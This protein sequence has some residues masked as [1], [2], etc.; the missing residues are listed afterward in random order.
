MPSAASFSGESAEPAYPRQVPVVCIRANA[1]TSH[2]A[3]SLKLEQT[4]LPMVTPRS[5]ASSAA[6]PSPSVTSSTVNT[7][8]ATTTEPHHLPSTYG[9]ALNTVSSRNLPLSATSCVLGCVTPP[10][11]SWDAQGAHSPATAPTTPAAAAV[12]ATRQLCLGPKV[13]ATVRDK[14]FVAAT[15]PR[16][17]ASNMAINHLIP[18][19]LSSDLSPEK[20]LPPH[21]LLPVGFAAC[22]DKIPLGAGALTDAATGMQ[23]AVIDPPLDSAAQL[24]TSPDDSNP[25]VLQGSCS[26]ACKAVDVQVHP[27]SPAREK[28]TRIPSQEDSTSTFMSTEHDAGYTHGLPSDMRTVDPSATEGG[29]VM[30]SLRGTAEAGTGEG[31]R[32]HEI[33]GTVL[34]KDVLSANPRIIDFSVIGVGGGGDNG[35]STS[36]PYLA[37]DED[38]CK[39]VAAYCHSDWA[40]LPQ[41]R[42]ASFNYTPSA[43]E[44]T[45]ELITTPTQVATSSAGAAAVDNLRKSPSRQHHNKLLEG[46]FDT[47]ANTMSITPFT[48]NDISGDL[49]PV[50]L[51]KAHQALANLHTK[52]PRLQTLGFSCSDSNGSGASVGMQSKQ[53]AVE[54]GAATFL[55]MTSSDAAATIS[56]RVARPHS[57]PL[58]LNKGMSAPPPPT[59]TTTCN[60]CETG[61]TENSREGAAQTTD[62]GTENKLQMQFGG[63]CS[64]PSQFKSASLTPPPL[65]LMDA[66]NHNTL[67]SLTCPPHRGRAA[68]VLGSPTVRLS[69]VADDHVNSGRNNSSLAALLEA[70]SVEESEKDFKRVNALSDVGHVSRS[71]VGVLAARSEVQP[72]PA[73]VVL[74]DKTF[75]A[76]HLSSTSTAEEDSSF[77]SLPLPQSPGCSATGSNNENGK[78]MYGSVAATHPLGTAAKVAGAGG[79]G[80]GAGS[81]TGCRSGVFRSSL[82]L[83][84]QWETY[85]DAVTSTASSNSATLP[86][87]SES[88]VH[89]NGGAH[90]GLAQVSDTV[91]TN[92]NLS[93]PTSSC[94]RPDG[95][96]AN[97][98]VEAVANGSWSIL[99]SAEQ[100]QPAGA[101][102]H[103]VTSASPSLPRDA[104]RLNF[105]SGDGNGS[106]NSQSE[107][108]RPLSVDPSAALAKQRPY[109]VVAEGD[110]IWSEPISS[111]PAPAAQPPAEVTMGTPAR[112]VTFASPAATQFVEP[113][114]SPWADNDFF[115]SPDYAHMEYKDGE[116]GGPSEQQVSNVPLVEEE[117]EVLPDVLRFRF[118]HRSARAQ[119]SSPLSGAE[120]HLKAPAWEAWSHG[121][122]STLSKTKAMSSGEDAR[123]ESCAMHVQQ[124]TEAA[125]PILSHGKGDYGETRNAAGEGASRVFFTKERLA[126][127]AALMQARRA[128]V[129][130]IGSAHDPTAVAT[131]SSVGSSGPALRITLTTPSVATTNTISL[132][133]PHFA[134]PITSTSDA[135]CHNIK[136][137]HTRSPPTSDDNTDAAKYADDDN[138]GGFGGSVL[139]KRHTISARSLPEATASP[140]TSQPLTRERCAQ[141]LA[142]LERGSAHVTSS[143]ASLALN[144]ERVIDVLRDVFGDNAAVLDSLHDQPLSPGLPPEP[145]SADDA[146]P[147]DLLVPGESLSTVERVLEALSFTP[148]TNCAFGAN[149]TSSYAVE[150]S[151]SLDPQSNRQVFAA[152][153]GVSTAVLNDGYVVPWRTHAMAVFSPHLTAAS[154]SAEMTPPQ[155]DD[156]RDDADASMRLAR[157]RLF[158]VS[159]RGT[160]LRRD[161]MAF[162]VASFLGTRRLPDAPTA[163]QWTEKDILLAVHQEQQRMSLERDGVRETERLEDVLRAA[164]L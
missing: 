12:P 55:S 126:S 113:L 92:G 53:R 52:Q 149:V 106:P 20:N 100:Q 25:L 47:F 32:N 18:S 21:H 142:S 120:V 75:T 39:P 136:A 7:P 59:S 160:N 30:G 38:K 80:D 94:T 40:D 154:A 11:D 29:D 118:R 98:T 5:E 17:G 69:P 78:Y 67:E 84:V 96:L 104:R 57:P 77:R 87:L 19:S 61:A 35:N 127:R 68:D 108:D 42:S 13:V 130:T 140:I 51:Y 14:L 158:P 150:A 155:E 90:A 112:H 109:H 56:S 22:V 147:A 146:S 125:V 36:R 163:A 44:T 10:P 122:N 161:A 101:P 26:P 145:I 85:G 37:D 74:K 110:D 66:K 81:R 49:A 103:S 134:T 131:G 114:P 164:C 73:A 141:L 58:D 27:S 33:G 129:Q 48:V 121:S 71:G 117:V 83:S 123:T 138:D 15:A 124:Q 152:D 79:G 119:R 16:N 95:L 111:A 115:F 6:S 64:A 28:K 91:T 159:T 88:D 43:A 46:T 63:N 62:S 82:P 41:S 45:A 8:A 3:G 144:T 76:H 128:G 99:G 89:K 162:S 135:T 102:N 133:L 2:T 4:P 34:G 97:S 60:N 9:E 93:G 50:S 23:S 151:V 105:H 137:A 132:A 1:Q 143:T 31:C 148:L 70:S 24:Q 107:P 72:S 86:P 54:G 157:Q 116:E 156:L 139:Q 153:G 65:D